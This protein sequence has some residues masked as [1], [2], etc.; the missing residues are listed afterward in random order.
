MAD[1]RGADSV[2]GPQQPLDKEQRV[3]ASEATRTP[4][5]PPRPCPECAYPRQTLVSEGDVV[6]IYRCP[7]CGHLSAPVKER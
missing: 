6:S 3:E 2:E 5:A 1:S 7:T 4:A